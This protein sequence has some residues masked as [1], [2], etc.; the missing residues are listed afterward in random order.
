VLDSQ[1]LEALPTARLLV[2]HAD[3]GYV[4]AVLVVVEGR[5][6]ARLTANRVVRDMSNL[7]SDKVT[8]EFP[9]SSVQF[10]EGTVTR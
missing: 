9:N 8:I 7:G 3:I 10:G 6:V 4:A 1:Q 2:N 5:P